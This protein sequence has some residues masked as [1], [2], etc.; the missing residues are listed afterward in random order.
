VK[1]RG[2][3]AE[4]GALTVNGQALALTDDELPR[5]DW[6]DVRR[7]VSLRAGW[8]DVEIRVAQQMEV[9]RLTGYSLTPSDIPAGWSEAY[10]D[11]YYTVLKPQ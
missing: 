5:D 6:A 4:P 2:R 3:G 9:L 7:T 11:A 1:R 8:N 10:R